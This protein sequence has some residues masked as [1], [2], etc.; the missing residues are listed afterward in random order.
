MTYHAHREFFL[1][2][3][4][5]FSV[6]CVFKRRQNKW[7]VDYLSLVSIRR[8][9]TDEFFSRKKEGSDE[10]IVYGLV[11][12]YGP[13]EPGVKRG[14][15]FQE[16]ASRERVGMERQLFSPNL[17]HYI[18]IYISLA[19]CTT[20]YVSRGKVARS[21]DSP[22]S[23]NWWGTSDGQLRDLKCDLLR[24]GY[25]MCMHVRRVVDLSAI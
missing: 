14:G 7:Q 21:G 17:Y 9:H 24:E 25:S 16:L 11:T 19:C 23:K 13:C 5:I 18:Y 8:Y 1:P 3:C 10:C 20:C 6:L 22:N 2:N 4:H 15:V 12:R